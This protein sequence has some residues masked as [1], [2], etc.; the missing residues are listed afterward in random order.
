MGRCRLAEQTRKADAESPDPVPAPQ[1][2]ERIVRLSLLGEIRTLVD[3][4]LERRTH[5]VGCCECHGWRG[6]H[7]PDCYLGKL[8]RLMDSLDAHED[9]PLESALQSELFARVRKE[10]SWLTS[11]ESDETRIPI[12]VGRLRSWLG[13][14][15]AI[16]ALSP[17]GAAGLPSTR[18]AQGSEAIPTSPDGENLKLSGDYHDIAPNERV[19]RVYRHGHYL[20]D[21]GALRI[22]CSFIDEPETTGDETLELPLCAAVLLEDGRIVRGHRHDDCIQ[23]M[24][25]WAKAGQVVGR[26]TMERQ[27]FLTSRGRFVNRSDGAALVRAAG[28]LSAHTGRPFSG[29]CLT[30]EDLYTGSRDV[31]ASRPSPEQA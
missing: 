6:A 14:I 28:L 5:P 25:K 20:L 29:D 4:M 31:V 3:E 24:E 11:G 27:G 18:E 2:K 12:P 22:H 1:E 17:C 23:T 13:H 15:D 9:E 7:S 21:R 26:A 10:M 30:S 8:E 19:V 16:E